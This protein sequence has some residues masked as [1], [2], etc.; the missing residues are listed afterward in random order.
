MAKR[1]V[2]GI[3]RH[4]AAELFSRFGVRRV[5]V[6]EICRHSGVSKVTFY[7]YYRNKDDL[8]D[9]IRDEWVQAGFAAFDEIEAL[10]IPYP[11]KIDRMTRWRIEHFSGIDDEF[12]REL[13]SGDDIQE[14]AKRRFLAN[15]ERARGRG[16]IRPDVSGELIW[17]VSE[18][19][20]GMVR[21]GGWRS[22]TEDYADFQA[23]MRTLF[24]YGLLARPAP[25]DRR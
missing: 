10:D 9:A 16:E 1:D 21:D 3:I 6:Q 13:F 17:L 18:R 25:V 19:L 23:Q 11:E 2:P 24:F 20:Q 22:V 14:E 5:T 15:L 12:R 4:G 7:K 8:V